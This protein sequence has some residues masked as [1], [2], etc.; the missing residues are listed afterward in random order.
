MKSKKK[1][2]KAPNKLSTLPGQKA[3]KR[4]VKETQSSMSE[5]QRAQSKNGQKNFPK[6]T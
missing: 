4:K 6:K 5:K 2:K 3:R 1:E